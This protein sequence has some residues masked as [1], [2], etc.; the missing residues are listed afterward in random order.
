[1]RRHELLL[2]S[3]VFEFNAHGRST[4]CPRPHLL[5][6]LTTPLHVAQPHGAPEVTQ[7]PPPSPFHRPLT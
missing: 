1:M 4:Q 2:L 5:R 3:A 6:S 7:A